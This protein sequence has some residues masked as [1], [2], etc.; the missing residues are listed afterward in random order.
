MLTAGAHAPAYQYVASTR[1]V[2]TR[3]QKPES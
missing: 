1:Q 3:I 2:E